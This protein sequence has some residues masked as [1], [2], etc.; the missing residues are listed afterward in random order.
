MKFLDDNTISYH[1]AA[2]G[3][4]MDISSSP[5]EQRFFNKHT[6]DILSMCCSADKT[7]MFTGEQGPKCLIH[8]WDNS[9]S[10]IKTYK[11]MIKGTVALACNDKY[12][13]A[14]GMDDDHI[15]IVFD[16]KTGAKYATEKG[17]K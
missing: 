8:E 14:A 11:G 6:D 2:L 1:T 12:L 15:I 9:G 3:V 16:R 5:Q 10:L 4:I 13:A 7:S 17:G